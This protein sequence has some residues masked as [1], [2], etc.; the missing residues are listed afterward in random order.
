MEQV[1]ALIYWLLQLFYYLLIGRI[2]MSWIPSINWYDQPFRLLYSI[3]EPVMAPFRRLIP[4]IGMMDISP[5]ILFLLLQFV[6]GILA[7][8]GR[9][10]LGMPGAF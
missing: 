2:I 7:P 9:T 6:L 10:G 3:T 1:L 5:I 4:P 8:Y